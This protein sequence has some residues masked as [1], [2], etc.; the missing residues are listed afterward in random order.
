MYL[1]RTNAEGVRD[2]EDVAQARIALAALNSA[3]VGPINPAAQRERL[4]GGASLLPE[5]ADRTT[6]RCVGG[7]ARLHA[8]IL[9]T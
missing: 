9:S 7:R 8:A 4:L 6:E 2:L 5:L 1:G 3:V